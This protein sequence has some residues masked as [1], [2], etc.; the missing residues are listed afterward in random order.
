MKVLGIRCVIRKKRRFFE[1]QQSVVF[2][3]RLDRKFSAAALNEKWVT[4]ITYLPLNGGFVY[5]SAIQDLYHNKPSTKS[6]LITS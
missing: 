4:D 1:K 3:N 2:P 6:S 5:L